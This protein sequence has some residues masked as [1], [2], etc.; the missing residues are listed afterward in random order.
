M[1]TGIHTY[2]LQATNTADATL[3]LSA[4]KRREEGRGGHKDNDFRRK[5]AVP[6][7][8]P[9]TNHVLDTHVAQASNVRLRHEAT[10]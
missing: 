3:S 8:I 7:K 9:T 5:S 4:T 1:F 10:K 6:T 2:L